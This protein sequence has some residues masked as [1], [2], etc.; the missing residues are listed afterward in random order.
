MIAGS[1]A[2]STLPESWFAR[3]SSVSSVAGSAAASSA[4]WSWFSA[5]LRCPSSRGK[6]A[7]FHVPCIAL[8]V[9]SNSHRDAGKSAAANGPSDA[10]CTTWSTLSVCGNAVIPFHDFTR[11][12][13]SS[14]DWTVSGIR[15]MWA[16]PSSCC[17]RHPSLHGK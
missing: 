14:T 15:S 1:E 12:P 9:K 8:F 5:I 13:L 2:V 17:I 11:T 10:V 7:L 16:S 3:A 4:H 6:S